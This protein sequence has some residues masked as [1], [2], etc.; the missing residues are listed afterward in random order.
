MTW[1]IIRIDEANN[2]VNYNAALVS[3]ACTA[4]TVANALV[5]AIPVMEY[6]A[7]IAGKPE[8]QVIVVEAEASLGGTFYVYYG[9]EKSVSLDYDATPEEMESAVNT[10]TGLSGVTVSKFTH[11]DGGFAGYAW[12]V[13]FPASLGNVENIIT[14]DQY[15]TGTNAAL[16][17]YG[18]FNMTTI[19]EEDDITGHF[20]IGFGAEITSQ[21]ALQATD[22]TIMNALHNLTNVDKVAMIGVPGMSSTTK[23][24]TYSVFCAS[25]SG[26][27]S[28][29][30]AYSTYYINSNTTTYMQ[31]GDVV[32]VSCSGTID[33]SAEIKSFDADSVSGETAVADRKSVV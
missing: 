4:T 22:Q 19:A 5:S 7:C 23:Y 31:V 26:A 2:G 10:F 9:G 16:N 24:N 29:G 27:C 11:T 21:L 33:G 6:P 13:T 32:D 12:A 15:I 28:S 20:R 18:M 3:E 1:P 30:S 14:D 8:I 17:T 25:G